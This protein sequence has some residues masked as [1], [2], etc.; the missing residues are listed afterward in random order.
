MTI[1][2]ESMRDRG[3]SRS[4]SPD[5]LSTDAF[6]RFFRAFDSK[7][8]LDV[9][10]RSIDSLSRMSCTLSQAA[11]EIGEKHLAMLKTVAKLPEGNAERFSGNNGE[12]DLRERSMLGATVQQMHDIHEIVRD[13]WSQLAQEAE[14]CARDNFVA[15]GS[16]LRAIQGHMQEGLQKSAEAG[17]AAGEHGAET[18]RRAT[19]NGAIAMRRT[20]DAAADSTR[21][22]SA[23]AA[24]AARKMGEQGSKQ[25]K[26]APGE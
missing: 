17:R 21:K 2:N 20:G 1:T 12:L 9:Q 25:G 3:L 15:L 6:T 13:C 11:A 23:E 7:P 14:A 4:G 19:E 5:E 24:D 22:V 18:M 10:L 26:V 8:L 16:N